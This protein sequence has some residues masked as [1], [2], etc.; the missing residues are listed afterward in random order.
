MRYPRASLRWNGWGETSK[1][2]DTHGRDGVLWAFVAK[3]LDVPSLPETPA[4]SLEKAKLGP[5][6]LAKRELDALG[7]LTHPDRVKTDS[8]ERA[9]HSLGRSYHDLLRLRAGD[10]S[11][12][13][14]LIQLLG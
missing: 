12:A 6:R 10:L 13:P 2:F 3:A 1:R 8:F 5:S 14:R 11:T 4:V 9:L 7:G